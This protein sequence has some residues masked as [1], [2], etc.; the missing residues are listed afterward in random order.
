MSFATVR[1]A[2]DAVALDEVCVVEGAE[3]KLN[4]GKKDWTIIENT[5][6]HGGQCN[7]MALG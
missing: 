5:L 3:G 1:A 6:G 4:S 2:G 7:P